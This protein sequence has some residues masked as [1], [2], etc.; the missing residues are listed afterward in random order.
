[1]WALNLILPIALRFGAGFLVDWLMAKFPFL[2]GK[3][4]ETRKLIEDIVKDTLAKIDASKADRK[5]LKIQEKEHIQEMKSRI[6]SACNGVGCST[7]L[8]GE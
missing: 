6:R 1:M 2:K 3:E 8:K 4:P 7:D 5:D